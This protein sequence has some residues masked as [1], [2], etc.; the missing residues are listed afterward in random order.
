MQKKTRKKKSRKIV[1]RTFVINYNN[2]INDFTYF[3]C[4][5]MMLRW[6]V[7]I[8]LSWYTNTLKLH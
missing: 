5:L 4:R 2:E 7:I 3:K 1:K 8:I 6:I